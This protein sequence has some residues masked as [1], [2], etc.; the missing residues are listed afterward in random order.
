MNQ[1]DW[2][3]RFHQF[4]DEQWQ[5]I[6]NAIGKNV[7][8]EAFRLKL[9]VR[10]TQF[11]N[12]RKQPRFKPV[13]QRNAMKSIARLSGRLRKKLELLDQ[14]A[15]HWPPDTGV[16]VVPADVY[17]K[18]YAKW[19]ALIVDLQEAER[20][21]KEQVGYIKRPRGS[22]DPAKR[23]FWWNAIELYEQFSGN[24]VGSSIRPSGRRLGEA[25]GPCVRFLTELTSS[26]PNEKKP[27]GHQVRAVIRDYQKSKGSTGL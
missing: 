27:K 14:R 12:R 22:V 16:A 5:L 11:L 9:G 21:A 3:R 25:G 17:R 20:R 8:D 19:N 26:V 2:M 10:V 1:N 13:G 6:L 18:Q 23:L 7:P 24:E 15:W 4:T